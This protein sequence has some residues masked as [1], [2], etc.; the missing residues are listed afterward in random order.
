MK[1]LLFIGL[2]ILFWASYAMYRRGMKQH[3]NGMRKEYDFSEGVRG[4]ILL[5]VPQLYVDLDVSK[6]PTNKEE[7]LSIHFEY[8]T[9]LPN[10]ETRML[11]ASRCMEYLEKLCEVTSSNEVTMSMTLYPEERQNG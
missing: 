3:N 8:T 4:A 6:I 11:L 7:V 2:I 1:I 9:P 10:T 5:K